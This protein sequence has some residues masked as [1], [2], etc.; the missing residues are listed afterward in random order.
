MSFVAVLVHSFYGWG[1]HDFPPFPDEVAV[2][3]FGHQ[4]CG[5]ARFSNMT[6]LKTSKWKKPLFLLFYTDSFRL[7]SNAGWWFWKERLVGP[8]HPSHL[9][10]PTDFRN[11]DEMLFAVPQNQ[12]WALSR[13]GFPGAGLVPRIPSHSCW[14]EWVIEIAN[15][16]REF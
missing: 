7:L 6:R 11:M 5:L 16:Y 4:S 1:I 3:W 15:L 13:E 12:T 14:E 9:L 10:S 8:W 2:A